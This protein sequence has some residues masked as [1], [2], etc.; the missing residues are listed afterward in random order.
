[1]LAVLYIVVTIALLG[2][3]SSV[4][5]LAQSRNLALT[6]TQQALMAASFTTA[7]AASLA[8]WWFGMRT[9]VTA[10]MQMD[11]TPS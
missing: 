9:G 11:R 5:L 10:L 2:W 7:A 8:V 1:V 3:P 6:G 4:Y